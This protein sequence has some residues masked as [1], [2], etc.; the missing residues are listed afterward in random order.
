MLA[1]NRAWYLMARNLS[2]EASPEERRELQLLLQEDRHLQQQFSILKDFWIPTQAQD[3]QTALKTERLLVKA[4]MQEQKNHSPKTGMLR[5]FP[6]SR[7][8]WAVA[9][10]I[11]TLIAVGFFIFRPNSSAQVVDQI[12][13]VDSVSIPNGNRS[14]LLLPDG[15]RV[16]LNSGSTLRYQAFSGKTREVELIGEA[17]F[18]VV[19]MPGKPFIVHAEGINIKVL[20]TSF[21]VRCYPEDKN[22]EATLLHGAIAVTHRD[23]P[24]KKTIF[25]KPNQKLSISKMFT[26]TGNSGSFIPYNVN[27]LDS[28][29][30]P[31]RLLETAWVYNRLEF[32]NADFKTLAIKMERW[33][34]VKI[35]L[36]DE[37]VQ[38]LRFVGSFEKETVSEALSALQSVADFS[39]EIKNNEINIQSSK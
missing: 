25:L 37:A 14:Q 18:D 27:D 30:Q 17:Y 16:W 33:Y 22:I 5:Y 9:A 1:N 34:N 10:S 23:D 26:Q 28:T 21:N 19:K 11:I 4:K 35:V 7:S 15:S 8:G 3:L 32:K 36:A 38:Q 13:A 24:G 12:L 31:A 2:N 29:I 39:Y 6:L 20:G